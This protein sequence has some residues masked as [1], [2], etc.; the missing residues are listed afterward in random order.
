MLDRLLAVYGLSYVTD[1]ICWET[2]SP[3]GFN[4]R[5]AV[6]HILTFFFIHTTRQTLQRRVAG[7]SHG[8]YIG[9]FRPTVAAVP[10]LL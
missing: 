2:E 8:L 9:L 1:T 7:N 10:T 6:V 3:I 4:V 5:A